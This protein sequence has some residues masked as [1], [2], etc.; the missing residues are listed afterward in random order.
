MRAAV[1][2]GVGAACLQAFGSVACDDSGAE[3]IAVSSSLRQRLDQAITSH[4]D[5]PKPGIV[6]KDIFPLFQ[7]NRRSGILLCGEA[8]EGA[9]EHEASAGAVSADGRACTETWTG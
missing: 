4:P 8:E 7:V 5:F 2:G 3:R 6:F 9:A 1:A